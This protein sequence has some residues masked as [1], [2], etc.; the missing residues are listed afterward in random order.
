VQVGAT[1]FTHRKNMAHLAQKVPFF[2][3]FCAKN[4]KNVHC[5]DLDITSDQ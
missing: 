5:L 2:C 4:A 3:L 1:R